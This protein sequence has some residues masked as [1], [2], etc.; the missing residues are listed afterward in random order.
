MGDCCYE[1]NPESG[2]IDRD[3]ECTEICTDEC[4][5]PCGL[6]HPVGSGTIAGCNSTTLPHFGV[7]MGPKDGTCRDRCYYTSGNCIE[8]EDLCG[9]MGELEHSVI[10]KPCATEVK[11]EYTPCDPCNGSGG[12][13][14][15]NYN[16]A[17][18]DV[19]NDR[20]DNLEAR[21]TVNEVKNTAQDAAIAD[22][23][24]NSVID[25]VLENDVFKA[26][27]EDGT[28]EDLIGNTGVVYTQDQ[29]DSI[30]DNLV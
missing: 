17:Q 16:P 29:V 27:Y 8:Y 5:D 11:Y 1:S 6:T 18:D 19:Q 13:V 28:K 9:N 24:D 23:V 7:F 22:N 12:G 25:H 4:V 20:L 14:Y 21:V 15:N 30:Y 10:V 3:I 26:V 2:I